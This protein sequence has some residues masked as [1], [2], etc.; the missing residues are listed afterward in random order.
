MEYLS[1]VEGI[2]GF[3]DHV[4]ALEVSKGRFLG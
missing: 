1:L 2:M 4:C 3:G